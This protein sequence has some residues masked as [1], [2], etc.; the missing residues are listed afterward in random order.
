MGVIGEA[1][2]LNQ[3]NSDIT[4]TD[5]TANAWS[6]VWD[7]Q[8][9]T[10]ISHIISPEHTLAFYIEDDS[11]AEVGNGDCQIRIEIRDT[12]ENDRRVIFGPIQYV[13]VKEFQDSRSKAKFNVA[14]DVVVKERYHIVVVAKDNG[15][16]DASD[17]Y[18]DLEME[19]VRETL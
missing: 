9:P 6:D 18:F 8:V 7:Y 4:E 17:S 16:I 14:D 2:H 5:G 3:N 11:P 19:R 1:F 15:T 10:G 13:R 12:T